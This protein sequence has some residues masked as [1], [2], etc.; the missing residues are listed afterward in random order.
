[1]CFN[2]S[3]LINSLRLLAVLASG[4]PK[5]A[6]KHT[7]VSE[8]D[9]TH[10]A[11][12]LP[13]VAYGAIG[14]RR[15]TTIRSKW[16]WSGSRHHMRTPWGRT[17]RGEVARTDNTGRQRLTGSV[18]TPDIA[19]IDTRGQPTVYDVVIT[20][21]RAKGKFGGSAARNA[22]IKTHEHYDNYA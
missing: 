20:G 14:E 18:A 10:H 9:S 22:E 8:K 16:Q 2:N 17:H 13:V 3:N 21:V 11:F 4:R 12:C 1:M 19:S 15:D 6:E 7:T 5:R